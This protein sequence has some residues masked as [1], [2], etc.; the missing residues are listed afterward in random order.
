MKHLISLNDCTTEE[1]HNLLNLAM[2]LKKE[3]YAGIKHHILKGK[4]LGMIFTK[5]SGQGSPS[6]SKIRII[7]CAK[8]GIESTSVPSKSNK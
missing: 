1:I 7:A 2:K 5:S 3:N 4:S 6:C 8:V